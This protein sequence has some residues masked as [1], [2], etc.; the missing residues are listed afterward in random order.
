MMDTLVELLRIE[1]QR[2][3]MRSKSAT[4]VAAVGDQDRR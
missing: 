3:R 2:E 4:I 1:V